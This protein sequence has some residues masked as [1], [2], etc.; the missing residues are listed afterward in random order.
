MPKVF[1]KGGLKFLFYSD[2]GGEPMH[3]HVKGTL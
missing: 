3:V 1:E 2:E